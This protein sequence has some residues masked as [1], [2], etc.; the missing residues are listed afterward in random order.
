M[1]GSPSFQTYIRS[2]T[3]WPTGVDNGKALL[4]THVDCLELYW[5]SWLVYAIWGNSILLNSLYS[6]QVC[7]LF[8]TGYSLKITQVTNIPPD[9]LNYAW[10]QIFNFTGLTY[11]RNKLISVIM[12]HILDMFTAQR[13][14]SYFS[15]QNYIVT[16]VYQNTKDLYTCTKKHLHEQIRAVELP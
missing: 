15:F 7:C 2:G 10:V 6:I 5:I 1:Y 13:E 14:F 4:W 3:D 8:V 9:L 16:S 12:E 11:K